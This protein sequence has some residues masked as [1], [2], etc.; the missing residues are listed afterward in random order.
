[1][2]GLPGGGR[3]S[4]KDA[5]MAASPGELAVRVPFPRPA[6]GSIPLTRGC[7]STATG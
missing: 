1:M 4:V 5:N 3:V 7:A 6:A 2:S